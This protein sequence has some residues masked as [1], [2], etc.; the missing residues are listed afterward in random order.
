MHGIAKH[1]AASERTCTPP[2][3]IAQAAQAALVDADWRHRVAPGSLRVCPKLVMV[4]AFLS[5]S[6]ET[7]AP[8]LFVNKVCPGSLK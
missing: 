2:A 3:F 6:M 7:A 5:F 8:W 4:L 1:T